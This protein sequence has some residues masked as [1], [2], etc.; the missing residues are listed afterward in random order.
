MTGVITAQLFRLQRHPSP[1][2]TFGYF[3]LGIPL[4]SLFIA[5]SVA[6]VLLGAWRFWRQQSAMVRGKVLAGG[7]EINVIMGGS[8]IV[9]LTF[10]LVAVIWQ[11]AVE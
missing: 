11:G 9:G 6:T 8:L 7:W 3:V 4:A 10:L 1:D 5:A 2:P